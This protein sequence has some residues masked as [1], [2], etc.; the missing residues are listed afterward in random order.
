VSPDLLATK[1]NHPLARKNLVPR[2]RL[3]QLLN[4]AWR[5][6][7]KMSLVSAPAGYGKTT[8]VIEWLE[9]LQTRTSWLSLDKADNDPTR[10]LFY[11]IAA[12][13]KIDEHIGKKTGAMLQSGQ[14]LPPEIVMTSLINEIANISEPFILILDDYHV[15]EALPIH[16]HLEFLVDHQPAQMHLVIITREDPP[17][18]VARLRARGQII[19]IRQNDLRFSLDESTDFLNQVMGLNLAPSQIVALEH[20][21]EGWIAGLQLAALSMRSRDDI[22]GFIQAFTGSSH[23]VLDYLIEEVFKQQPADIQDFLL[24]TSILDRLSGPLCDAVTNRTNSRTL[25]EHLEHANL[26]IIPLDQSCNWY[27]YHQLF[28]D[29]LRQRLN[30]S[31]SYSQKELHQ[32]ASQWFQ[33]EGL[34]SEAIQH[35]LAAMDWETAAEMIQDNAVQML[36]VGELMTLIHWIK[37]LPNSVIYNRPELCQNYG[38]ALTLTGQLDTAEIYLQQ[39]ENLA[40]NDETLLGPILV[41]RAYHL[42][43]RG[44]VSQAIDYA[45]RA[46]SILPQSD[47]LSRGLAALTLG[48][49]YW[50][51]GDFQESERAFLEVDRAAQL[52]G[53]HYA[54]MTALTYLGN[55]QAVFGHLHRAAELCQQVI[56]LGGQSPPVAPAHIEL[57]SLFYEW[58]RLDS[59]IEQVQIG[60]EQSQRTGNPLI[61]ADG[62]RILAII[63]QARGEP[64]AALSTLTLVDQLVNSHQVSPLARYRIAVCH[65]QIALAQ[66][67]LTSAQFWAEQLAEPTDTSLFDPCL[68]LTPI[69]I[70]LA[71]Q[72]NKAAAERLIEFYNTA[73]QKGCGAGMVEVRLLQSLAAKT[74]TDALSFLQDA[75]KKAQPEG[76]I[77][78]FVDKGEPMKA[79]LER[80]KSQGGELKEYILMLLS[81]FVT[82]NRVSV[83]QKLVEPLSERELDVLRLLEQGMSNREIARRLVVTIGTVKSHV[84]SIISKLGVSSRNQAVSQARILKLL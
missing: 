5:S 69:R 50:N 84:H 37:A 76:F 1:L 55:I 24:K 4:E 10:F 62:Y 52:S 42:R 65:V 63:H 64:E 8:L 19:E 54:R 46:L 78:T 29:L 74:P 45:R 22:S 32:Q 73:C 59:A 11:I 17:L 57:A 44:D 43:V 18:P 16:Q 56:Q 21:T 81:A 34:L 61:L 80:L 83:S 77:R 39:A 41:A 70:L 53:N 20:R 67:N 27:R 15:I 48:L 68:G 47:A 51:R 9:G 66:D 2:L 13:Q 49:A 40:Q 75:L 23:Y 3:I 12:L 72:A 36:G 31:E 71:H 79:L 6:D 7:K 35:A 82:P 14:P 38:W 30:A 26:F 28:A 33:R 60:I 25:L 58:N